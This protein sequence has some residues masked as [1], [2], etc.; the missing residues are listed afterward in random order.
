[1]GHA[2][3]VPGNRKLE[4]LNSLRPCTKLQKCTGNEEQ[5]EMPK[6]NNRDIIA[7]ELTS[8]LGDFGF[9][10]RNKY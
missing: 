2:N 3:L 6:P 1:M 9:I 7:I 4:P 8:S 10:R 5:N